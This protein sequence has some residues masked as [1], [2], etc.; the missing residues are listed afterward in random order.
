MLFKKRK[1]KI[2]CAYAIRNRI[3][4][5]HWLAALK[6]LTLPAKAKKYETY[7]D[8]N[9]RIWSHWPGHFQAV[10]AQK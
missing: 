6:R 2:Y 3:K 5:F 1:A 10:D 9:K 4:I 8:C 7:S